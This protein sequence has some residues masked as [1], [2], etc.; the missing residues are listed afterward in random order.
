MPVKNQ[1]EAEDT[2]A[3]MLTDALRPQGIQVQV[4]GDGLLTAP[5][6]FSEW[7]RIDVQH[8]LGRQET[9]ANFNGVR[10]YNRTG[11][12]IVQCF[13]RLSNQGNTRAGEIA[14]QVVRVYEGKAGAGGI[15]FRNVRA[16]RI[17]AADGWFQ[18]NAVAEFDYDIV[19]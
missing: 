14:E 3:L 10:R 16:R 17:G 15:W 5:G 9:L 11:T 13:A 4:V 2:I 6:G 8:D 19:R 7:C 18:Y 12:I 1:Q